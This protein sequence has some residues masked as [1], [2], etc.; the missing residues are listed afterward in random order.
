MENNNFDDSL[1]KFYALKRDYDMKYRE[2]KRVIQKNDALNVKE[3]REK[4]SKIKM[5]CIGCKKAVGTIFTNKNGILKAVCGNMTNQC[6]LRIE[7]NRGRYVNL[8]EFMDALS[9]VIDENKTSIIK[10]KLNLLFQYDDE[11]TVLGLFKDIKEELTFSLEELLKDK[12]K[13]LNIV[14][15]LEEKP[16]IEIIKNDI[17]IQIATM[18]QT[19]IEFKES[20][21][22]KL[23]KD[24]VTNYNNDLIPLVHKLR[25]L[26]YKYMNMEYNEF[27]KTFHL[28]QK[29]YVIGDLEEEFEPPSVIEFTID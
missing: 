24:L 23:V 25:E 17:Y 3:K 20:N 1:N 11:E 10:L 6:D 27:D 21:N 18:K 22:M 16:E 2:K 14:N 13:Y 8:E 5:K 29:K 7:I 28:I 19:M 4:I 15:R 9:E 12:E 26:Q